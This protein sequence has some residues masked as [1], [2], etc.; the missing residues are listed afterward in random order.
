[1]QEVIRK[2]LREFGTFLEWN[3]KFVNFIAQNLNEDED[4][5]TV[6]RFC[7]NRR[8]DWN[9]FIHDC[10]L[11]EVQERFQHSDETV[12]RYFHV[13]LKSINLTCT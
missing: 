9:V 4:G 2:F 1:M 7:I 10:S 11:R 6:S 8:T 3:L 12:S 5:L 13:V